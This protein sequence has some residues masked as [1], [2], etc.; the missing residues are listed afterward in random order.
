MTRGVRIHLCIHNSIPLIYLP[1][2]VPIPCSFYYDCSVVQVE[3]KDGD[4]TEVLLLLSIDFAIFIFVVVVLLLQINVQL[5]EELSW[6]FDGDC[7]WQ[8]G[9]FYYINHAN[10]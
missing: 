2:T 5:Y 8:D 1:V 6:N 10:P 7:I 4:S 9:Y 3:V